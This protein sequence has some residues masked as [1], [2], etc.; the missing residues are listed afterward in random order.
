MNTPAKREIGV[1][2]SRPFQVYK[3]YEHLHL[4]PLVYGKSYV[5]ARRHSS[6][7]VQDL[8]RILNLSTQ[9]PV[10]RQCLISGKITLRSLIDRLKSIG[11]LQL[12]CPNIE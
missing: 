1:L 12:T 5:G 2:E 9:N 6:D 3:A 10:A 7:L 8:D 11:I 4:M